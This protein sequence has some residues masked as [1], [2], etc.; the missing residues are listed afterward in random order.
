MAPSLRAAT[1]QESAGMIG[2]SRGAITDRLVGS[3]GVVDLAE[4]LHLDGERVA[5]AIGPRNMCS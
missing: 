1:L 3:D 2:L 4:A 5:S